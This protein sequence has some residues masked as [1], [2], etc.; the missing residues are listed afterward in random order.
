V[1]CGEAVVFMLGPAER[2]GG[3]LDA[4]GRRRAKGPKL[5]QEIAVVVKP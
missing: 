5:R 2:Y 4:L 1:E 3:F